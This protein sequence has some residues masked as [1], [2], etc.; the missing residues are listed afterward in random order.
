MN[1]QGDTALS[2][3]STKFGKD[4]DDEMLNKTEYSANVTDDLLFR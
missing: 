3:R 4:I 2:D 1:I